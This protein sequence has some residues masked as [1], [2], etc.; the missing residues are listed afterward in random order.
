MHTFIKF[1][2]MG[3]ET[4]M[5]CL[6]QSQKRGVEASKIPDLC[7]PPFREACIS[8]TFRVVKTIRLSLE[9]VK[10]LLE[11]FPQLQIIH[12]YRDPRAIL[13]SR[14]RYEP[15]KYKIDAMSAHAKQ[16]CESMKQNA[17][18]IESLSKRYPDRVT[19]I[20]FES[21]ATKPLMTAGRI[22]RFLG[23]SFPQKLRKWLVSTTSFDPIDPRERLDPSRVQR[24]STFAQMRWMNEM[25][26]AVR[27]VIN[28][29][30]E[31]LLNRLGYDT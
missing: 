28:S 22:L 4:Y 7:V 1:G 9:L 25:S 26:P 23:W 16:L 31:D 30:C 19:S 14:Q 3:K 8:A 29:E 5:P 12:N 18:S 2:L 6:T 27:K 20:Q 10:P 24:N 13:R 11:E 21:M 17:D 15:R